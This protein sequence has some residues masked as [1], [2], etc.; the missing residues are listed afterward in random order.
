MNLKLQNHIPDRFSSEANLK[1]TEKFMSEL[2]V[3]KKNAEFAK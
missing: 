2:L 3:A 1:D